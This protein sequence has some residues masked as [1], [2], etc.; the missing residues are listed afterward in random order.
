MM[1]P[2]SAVG[3]VAPAPIDTVKSVAKPIGGNRIQLGPGQKRTEHLSRDGLGRSGQSG[4]TGQKGTNIGLVCQSFCCWLCK[5]LLFHL[6]PVNGLDDTNSGK[7]SL[8][9]LE[10]Q[11]YQSDFKHKV[12]STVADVTRFVGTRACRSQARM[13]QL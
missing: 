7:R 9:N 5:L 4:G 8:D 13:H 11:S 10:N 1:Q 6:D 12:G 3:L 2:S